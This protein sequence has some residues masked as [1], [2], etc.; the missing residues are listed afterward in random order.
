MIGL[1]GHSLLRVRH[2]PCVVMSMTTALNIGL[3]ALTA[4]QRALEVTS[5]N[6]ANAATPGYSRQRAQLGTQIP[7]TVDVGQMGRGTAVQSIDRLHD[8]L[9]DTRLQAASAE[10]GR[11]DY[12]QRSLAD[13]ELLFNE[14]G[15]NG[16]QARINQL[17]ATF[18]DLSG[19]PRINRLARG[20]DARTN[21]VCRKL[22]FFGEWYR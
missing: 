19:N 8:S 16:F 20:R 3:T 4:H 21:G 14:P 13:A 18:E 12:L 17:F 15:E 9:L 11:L 1:I 22:E 10:V 2:G 5:H 6:I 7:A